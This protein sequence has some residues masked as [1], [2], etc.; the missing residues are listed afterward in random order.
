MSKDGKETKPKRI[1]QL[2]PGKSTFC[3]WGRCVVGPD[4]KYFLLAVAFIVVP[5][6]LYCGL[7]WPYLFWRLEPYVSVPLAVFYFFFLFSMLT[8]MMITRYRDPGIIPRGLSIEY[9]P[10]NPWDYEEKKP[11]ETMRLNLK[12]DTKFRVKYC[13]TCNIY[14]PPRCTHCAVC[15]NCVERFDH[16]CPWVGNC[17]GRRNYQTFLA[18]VWSVVLG[19]IYICLLSIAHLAIVIVEAIHEEDEGGYI[20]LHILRYGF[21][22]AITLVYCFIAIGLV[23][24]LGTFHCMLLCKNQTTNEKLKGLY[25][26][27]INPYSKG[28]CLNF[29]SI[30]WAPIFPRPVPWR[31]VYHEEAVRLTK[32]K[33]WP[34]EKKKATS[35][36]K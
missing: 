24:F 36:R 2:W 22:S 10:E 32:R 7:V 18:F 33:Q 4:R 3:C 35:R 11:A 27:K 8:F 12:G 15:N 28:P 19:S 26:K 29:V 17:I 20:F 31:E 9:D 6:I 25:K 14:R 34:K 23:G 5:A 16:H 21:F 13:E 30:L 1:Y